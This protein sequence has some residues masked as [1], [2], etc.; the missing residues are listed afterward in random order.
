M[1]HQKRWK[2]FAVEPHFF[3]SSSSSSLAGTCCIISL[4]TCV[5]GINFELSRYPRYMFGIPEDI[6]HGYGWSM[7]CAWGGLGLTLL[8]GFLCTLAPSLYPPHTPV[9]HKPRQENGCVWQATAH[10]TDTCLILK[11]WRALLQRQF[12]PGTQS[13]GSLHTAW[14]RESTGHWLSLTW[15]LKKRWHLTEDDFSSSGAF[16]C[17]S[18]WMNCSVLLLALQEENSYTKFFLPLKSAS[19]GRKKEKN[20]NTGRWSIAQLWNLY[21]RS[22]YGCV[23]SHFK[24]QLCII[25]YPF[26]TRRYVHVL[27]ELYVCRCI[28]V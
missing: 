24:G 18:F 21:W 5:A 26:K 22:N 27:F 10:L 16:F 8:A 20:K 25:M 28:C 13:R 23:P 4:C 14:H 6:S 11:Q 7:F 1:M 17:P 9:V 15:K 3:S 12:Y 2:H 19:L